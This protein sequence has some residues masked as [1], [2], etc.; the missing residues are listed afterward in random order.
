[1]LDATPG[2]DGGFARDDEI[3]AGQQ[4][5]AVAAT[6][7]TRPEQGITSV[8]YV[9]LPE[10]QA[11]HIAATAHGRGLRPTLTREEAGAA[12]ITIRPG[13]LDQILSES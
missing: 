6:L 13:L 3:K 5:A 8:T 9:G 1:M 11:V 7:L 10:R 12:S 2:L 4:Q